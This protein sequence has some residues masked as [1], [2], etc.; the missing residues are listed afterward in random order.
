MN[1]E[2]LWG[3]SLQLAGKMFEFWGRMTGN[4]LQRQHGYQLVVVGQMRVLG[5][6]AAALLRYC[7]P[8]Q[9]LDVRL[10]RSPTRTR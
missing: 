6:Q 10:T 8:R 2:I 4:E 1:L 3:R 7:T 9:V 5:G